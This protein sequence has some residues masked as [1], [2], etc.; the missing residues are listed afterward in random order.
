[1]S[2]NFNLRNGC[3]DGARGKTIEH[4]AGDCNCR[5]A[6]GYFDHRILRKVVVLVSHVVGTYSRRH[7]HS[8]DG[9]VLPIMSDKEVGVGACFPHDTVRIARRDERGVGDEVEFRIGDKRHLFGA[10]SLVSRTTPMFHRNITYWAIAVV[11][12]LCAGTTWALTPRE[13][14][15]VHHQ[16]VVAY[17]AVDAAAQCQRGCEVMAGTLQGPSDTDMCPPGISRCQ[18]HFTDTAGEHHDVYIG[19]IVILNPGECI[20][21]GGPP[22]PECVNCTRDTHGKIKRSGSAITAFKKAHPCPANGRTIG[23]CPGYVIDHIVPLKRGGADDPSN[24]Q[25]QTKEQAKQKD[26]WE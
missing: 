15:A 24:M 7:V 2:G 1:M 13:A 12:F 6:S 8:S 26:R 11:T 17:G 20:P 9:V 18:I 21:V 19:N 14:C 10:C 16:V 22:A 5:D 3:R 4:P 23:T 25:W